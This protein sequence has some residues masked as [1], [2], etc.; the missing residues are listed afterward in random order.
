M[1]NKKI[2]KKDSVAMMSLHLVVSGEGYLE[3]IFN[4]DS[5]FERVPNRAC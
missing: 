4:G 2:V 5:L 1:F 3:I